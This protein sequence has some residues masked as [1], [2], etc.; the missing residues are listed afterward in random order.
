[1]AANADFVS[2]R[3]LGLTG[4]ILYL[5][6][7]VA[8][9]FAEMGVRGRLILRGDAAA[10]ASNILG[11][12]TLFRLS[13]AGEVLTCVCDA[14][15]AIILYVL[16]RPVSRNLALLAAAQR[17][18][19]TGVYAVTKLFLIAALVL[20]GGA[21]YPSAFDQEQLHALAYQSLRLHSLGYGMSLIFFGVHCVLLGWLAYRSGYAPRALGVLLAIG[22]VGYFVHSMTQMLAP[23]LAAS[24]FPWIMLPAFPAELWLALWLIVKGND[25]PL[26]AR[27]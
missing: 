8:A 25:G 6:I 5:Y 3:V 22:G 16:F 13:L 9:A 23:S 14:A 18:T 10:T 26:P 21:G 19:F 27:R 24:L 7:I 4:G 11:S 17:L 12:E 2:P 20:L 1:M 15:L